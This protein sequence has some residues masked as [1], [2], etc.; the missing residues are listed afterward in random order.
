MIPS[1]SEQRTLQTESNILFF[2]FFANKKI[3]L[4]YIIYHITRILCQICPVCSTAY[5]S[6]KSHLV[7]DRNNRSTID[8]DAFFSSLYSLRVLP[9]FYYFQLSSDFEIA[10]SSRR[11]YIFKRLNKI[12]LSIDRGRQNKLQISFRK[13]KKKLEVNTEEYIVRIF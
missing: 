5:I 10:F 7:F 13:K 2:H 1:A 11:L 12:F 3:H 6:N 9:C 8:R 4:L